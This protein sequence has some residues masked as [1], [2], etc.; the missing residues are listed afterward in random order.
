MT[1]EEAETKLHKLL[2]KTFDGNTTKGYCWVKNLF[3]CFH[4]PTNLLTVEI[5]NDMILCT[6][7]K[8][9]HTLCSIHNRTHGKI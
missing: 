8:K 5:L 6:Q 1:R 9:E 2:R 7:S 3:N 4:M